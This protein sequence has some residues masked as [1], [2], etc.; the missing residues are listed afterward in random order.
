MPRR[1]TVASVVLC[2]LLLA[3][4][5]AE[6]LSRQAFTPSGSDATTAGD[7]ALGDA[8]G[9]IDSAGAD[10]PGTG[11]CKV[12][13]DCPASQVLCSVQVS[14][15][16]GSCKAAPAPEGSPCNDS[17]ACTT[18]DQCLAHTCGG[19]AIPCED[20]NVCTTDG[21]DKLTGQCTHVSIKGPCNDGD[22][23]TTGDAC[24]GG[25]CIGTTSTLCECHKDADCKDDNNLCNGTKYCDKSAAVYKCKD[26]PATVVTCPSVDDSDCIKNSCD[27][28]T[29]QCSLQ[30]LEKIDHKCEGDQCWYLILAP[31]VT[32]KLSMTCEDGNACTNSDSCVKGECVSGTSTCV[33]QKN[34]DCASSEDG[35]LCNGTMYCDLT[36]NPP[37]CLVNPATKVVCPTGGDTQCLQTACDI[38]TGKCLPTPVEQ[39]A[40][41][42]ETDPVSGKKDCYKIKTAKATTGYI[43]CN[44]G[45]SC[46]ATEGCKGG[47]CGNSTTVCACTSTSDCTKFEDGDACNGTLFCN[48]AATPP[49]CQVNPQTVVACQTVGDT[50]C[51]T[52]ACNPATGQ[53]EATDARKV[54]KQC[55]PTN[56]PVPQCFTET[57]PAGETGLSYLKCDDGNPCTPTDQCLEGK[58]T[59][60]GLVTCSCTK[61]ADCAALDDGDLCNGTL[62]CDKS[63][64]QPTC[65]FN[66]ASVVACQTV[67]DTQCSRN[68]CDAKTGQCKVLP[69]EA[70]KNKCFGIIDAATQKQTGEQCFIEVVLPGDPTPEFAC[71]DGNPCTAN[72]GCNGKG[73][74][75]GGINTC[76]CQKDGDC[77][78]G[79]ACNGTLYCDKTVNPHKC[80]PNPATVVS[81][82]SAFDSLCQKNLCVPATG[83]CAL[84]SVHEGLVCDDGNPCTV[85]DVCG[86]GQCKAGTNTCLCQIDADCKEDGDACNGTMYCD[87]SGST[88]LCLVNP[89]TIVY[90][91]TGGDT[92]CLKNVCDKVDGQCKLAP[93][94]SFTPCEDGNPCTKGDTCE[95]GACQAGANVCD[96][97]SAPDCLSKD[98]GNA[99]NGT[100]FCDKSQVPFKCMTN[101]ATLVACKD[102]G[103][104]L[105]ASCDGA[106]GQCSTLADEAVCNDGNPCS[107]DSCDASSGE[108]KHATVNDGV[109][110]G[111]WM[112]KAGKCGPP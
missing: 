23:C 102:Q 96:C 100:L 28:K 70:T 84:Q 72:D 98:D 101:P 27:T 83:K 21:C 106:T 61:D 2:L 90:C 111:A 67:G 57:L 58:C 95:G 88:H 1:P 47:E 37:K 8:G 12:D 104:C 32:S 30:P 85:S 19:T 34:A 87:K 20:D 73:Q 108:C 16:D 97:Q 64:P 69:I 81:C 71:N 26:N 29:G 40:V 41:Q 53:C 99:C 94:S 31:G 51:L 36:Q 112:C 103:V 14:Q 7:T 44:D 4:C 25:Q 24:D 91:P 62:Y 79:D 107:L 75:Q 93:L 11:S 43:P 39:V 17:N 76:P 5:K 109:A 38:K 105:R 66:P 33:C 59:T 6:T 15:P 3:G 86:A 42:C 48:Q 92:A 55:Y 77:A 78:D 82:P 54:K 80:I 68:A 46:T 13:G 89:A 110:C 56:G 63:G 49:A 10:I 50:Q 52:N 45:D 18:G 74:C 9:D 65:A 60:T 22:A 35:N